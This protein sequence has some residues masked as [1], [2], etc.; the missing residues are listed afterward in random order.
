MNTTMTDLDMPE[1]MPGLGHAVARLHE[2]ESS[3]PSRTRMALWRARNRALLCYTGR[4][5]ARNRLWALRGAVAMS[6]VLALAASTSLWVSQ[7]PHSVLDGQALAV[8]ACESC[9]MEQ[10]CYL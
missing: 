1:Y 9:R 10:T 4:G 7:A 6:L 3:V 2:N 8:D 5:Q